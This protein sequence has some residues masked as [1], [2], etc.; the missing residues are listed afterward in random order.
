MTRSV[1][2]SCTGAETVCTGTRS[3]GVSCAGAGSAGASCAGAGGGAVLLTG[4]PKNPTVAFPVSPAGL[5]CDFWEFD[6]SGTGT[7]SPSG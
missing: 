3:V 1:G 2:V 6:V 4:A 7:V 5:S